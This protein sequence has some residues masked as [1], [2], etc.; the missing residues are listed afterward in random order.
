MALKVGDRIRIQYMDGEPQYEGR[1]G[2]VKEIGKD[3]W[4]DTYYRGTWG[5]CSL[6]PSAGDIYEILGSENLKKS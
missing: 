6:Y 3:P 5:G 4:G 1:E 2:T